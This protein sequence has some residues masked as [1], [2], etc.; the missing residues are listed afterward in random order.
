MLLHCC[1][2]CSR[3]YGKIK[4][5][6]S[7]YRPPNPYHKIMAI[8][9]S[10]HLPDYILQRY[11]FSVNNFSISSGKF[12]INT[13]YGKLSLESIIAKSPAIACQRFTHLLF[14]RAITNKKTDRSLC[15]WYEE[16]LPWCAHSSSS[17]FRRGQMHE[18]NRIHTRHL[19]VRLF[20]LHLNKC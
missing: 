20:G 5:I 12:Y 6:F 9:N 2:P 8:C 14:F 10:C 16:V 13:R 7:E 19:I 11:I 3:H 17:H 15:E 1:H 4:R 18:S